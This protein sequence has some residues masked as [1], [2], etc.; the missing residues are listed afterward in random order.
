MDSECVPAQAVWACAGR[1]EAAGE[2]LVERTD[3]GWGRRDNTGRELCRRA[4]H[5]DVSECVSGSVA[6]SV[7]LSVGR[8]RPHEPPRQCGASKRASHAAGAMFGCGTG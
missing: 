8:D 5:A 6:L 4:Q 3:Q 7:A 2:V 1:R